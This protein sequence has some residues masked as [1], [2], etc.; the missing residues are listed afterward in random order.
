[1]K[2]SI[3]SWVFAVVCL[4]AVVSVNAGETKGGSSAT[5]NCLSTAAYNSCMSNLTPAN[6]QEVVLIIIGTDNAGQSLKYLATNNC[7]G[8]ANFTACTLSVNAYE[9][10]GQNWVW[11]ERGD[12]VPVDNYPCRGLTNCT[13]TL[14]YTT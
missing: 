12:S 3:L 2:K 8:H 10:Q 14:T 7:P 4:G 9:L 1:M 5:I 6:A 11:A 13:I